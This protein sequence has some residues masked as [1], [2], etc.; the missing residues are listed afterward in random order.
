MKK[1]EIIIAI[2]S[3]IAFLLNLFLVPGGSV[4]TILMLSILSSIYFYFGFALFNNIRFRN[5]LKKES[6]K[7]IS[8]LQIIGAIGTGLAISLTLIGIMFKIM[9]WPGAYV[10]LYVGIFASLVILIIGGLKFSKN[11]SD[12]YLKIFK[13]IGITGGLAL[14]IV[15]SPR[16][17]L[18]DFKYR[19][20]HEYLNLLKQSME[21]PNNE[22]IHDKLSE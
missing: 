11:K 17:T 16:N 9:S 6:Y 2:L 15:I 7:G 3:I 22:D 4:L 5:I 19:N 13:R 10:N 1:T 21:N 8:A 18:L 12:Y 20:H 14:I